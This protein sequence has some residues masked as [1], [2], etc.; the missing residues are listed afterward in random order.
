[1]S[2]RGDHVPDIEAELDRLVRER[3]AERL[4]ARFVAELASD[5]QFGDVGIDS[6]HLVAV[7]AGLERDLRVDRI[8][9]GELAEIAGS[10]AHLVRY[11]AERGHLEWS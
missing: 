6:M 9:D 4:G 8:A 3:L 5:E 11:L 2:G 7:L 10:I 1:M